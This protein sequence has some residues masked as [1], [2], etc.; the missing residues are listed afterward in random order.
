MLVAPGETKW[1]PGLKI[2][3]KQKGASTKAAKSW[4]VIRTANPE[5][6]KRI[7]RIYS[8]GESISK[9]FRSLMLIP[10]FARIHPVNFWWLIGFLVVPS[11]EVRA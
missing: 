9:Q 3:D 7:V 2:Y 5:F 1:N 10:Q 11:R 6:K 4:E 8:R